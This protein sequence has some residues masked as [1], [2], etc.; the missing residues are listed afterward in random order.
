MQRLSILT[1]LLFIGCYAHA[2]D[3]SVTV[4]D[5]HTNK[6]VKNVLVQIHNHRKLIR[7][8]RTDSNGTIL[9]EKVRRSIIYVRVYGDSEKFESYSHVHSHLGLHTFRLNAELV[10]TK[11]YEDAIIQTEDSLY[12]SWRE[13]CKIHYTDLNNKDYFDSYG[14][15]DA[16]FPDG[17]SG[18]VEYLNNNSRLPNNT[19]VQR[20]EKGRVNFVVE[21][22]GSLSHVH[23]VYASDPEI[24]R[25]LKRLFWSMPKWTPKKIDY[26][27]VRS[28][29]SVSVWFIMVVI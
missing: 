15:D 28:V 1:L 11:S 3:V 27:P 10:P 5:M 16:K 17:Y 24:E 9:F 26:K 29:Q 21:A 23:V 19:W 13:A 14:I 25:E 7:S 2:Y 4:T 6:P 12:G 22:D 18:L 20:K 8:A